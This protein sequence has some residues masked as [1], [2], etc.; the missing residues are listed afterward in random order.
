VSEREHGCFLE[1]LG[2]EEKEKF[3]PFISF[4]FLQS[5]IAKQTTNHTRTGCL[6]CL[7]IR[8]SGLFLLLFFFSGVSRR[9][10]RTD[11]S[12]KNGEE[13]TGEEAAHVHSRSAHLVR[14][15][16][17]RFSRRWLRSFSFRHA[18]APGSDSNVLFLFLASEN[19]VC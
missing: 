14:E 2:D 9:R 10:R 8:G 7:P 13:H 18:L 19:L 3:P 15:S 1:R 5:S 6:L 12:D 11:N 16:S 4:P 17:G